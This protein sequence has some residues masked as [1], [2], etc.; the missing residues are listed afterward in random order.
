MNYT[1][2]YQKMPPFISNILV[3]AKAVSVDIPFFDKL[4]IPD[5]HYF[6]DKMMKNRLLK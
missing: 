3:K 2:L 4:S 6:E 1:P 5:K